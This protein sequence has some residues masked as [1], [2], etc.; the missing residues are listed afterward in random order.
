MARF[1]LASPNT[2]VIFFSFLSLVLGI[3]LGRVSQSSGAWMKNTSSPLPSSKSAE[4]LG[5]R[6]QNG[7]ECTPQPCPPCREK[8]G[9]VRDCIRRDGQKI[10]A[11][12]EYAKRIAMPAG[13]RIQGLLVGVLHPELQF[14]PG[15]AHGQTDDCEDPSYLIPWLLGNQV[16]L[17]SASRRVFLDLGAAA[18]NSSTGWFMRNYPVDF[19]EIHAFEVVPDLFEPPYDV[20]GALP[21]PPVVTQYEMMVGVSDEANTS[22]GV[23]GVDILRFITGELRIR[24]EDTL[25]VKMD[26]EGGEWEVLPALLEAPAVLRLID[27][28]FVETHYGDPIMRACGW[29]QFY[30]KKLEDALSLVNQLRQAGLRTHFWP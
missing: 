12:G 28:L 3:L 11:Y 14:R 22:L 17:N 30:P 24:E 15:Y 29:D 4:M 16:D 13:E 18:F 10:S 8:C 2:R 25:I 1:S 5:L 23:P 21:H 26:I 19:D 7:G 6:L 9:E 27:E 20:I